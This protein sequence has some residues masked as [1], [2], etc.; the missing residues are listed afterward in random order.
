ML[1]IPNILA[2]ALDRYSAAKHLQE[3]LQ[4]SRWTKVRIPTNQSLVLHI[5]VT[6]PTELFVDQENP[7]EGSTP[8]FQG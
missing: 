5:A 2:C 1:H 3:D 7:D 6:H 4:V 8:M